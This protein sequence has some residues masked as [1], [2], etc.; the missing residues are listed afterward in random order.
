MP[1]QQLTKVDYLWH[2][3]ISLIKIPL[4]IHSWLTNTPCLPS[5][6]FPAPHN[7]MSRGDICG[8]PQSGC[9]T[10]TCGIH[11]P[12]HPGLAEK[13]LCVTRSSESW[14]CNFCLLHRL[15]GYF[16][17]YNDHHTQHSIDHLSISRLSGYHVTFNTGPNHPTSLILNYTRWQVKNWTLIATCAKYPS[18]PF[19]TSI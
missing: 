7:L 8:E 9:T 4:D 15:V 13:D 5:I 16:V 6:T 19:T 3:R 2:L 12:G 1:M 10:W 17:S 14:M 18:S 11:G